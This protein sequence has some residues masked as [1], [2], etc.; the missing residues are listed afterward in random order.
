MRRGLWLATLIGLGLGAAPARA[1]SLSG[2][3]E[4]GNA[5]FYAGELDA[6]AE[7]Y[8][9]L[10]AAGVRDPDVYFNLATAYGRQ[11]KLGLA[12]LHY[13]R[14]LRL[15][16]GADD[17]VRGLA[18]AREALGHRRAERDGE[19]TVRTRPPLAETLVQPFSETQL[20]WASLVACL[21]LFGVLIVRRL[22]R[23]ETLRIG[24]GLAAPLLGLLL[25]LSGLGL[26][27]RADWLADGA[28]GV[29]LVED[30]ALREGPDPH[31][32]ERGQA[33]EGARARLFEREAGFVRVQLGDE[34]G[35]WLPADQVAAIQD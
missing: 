25:I 2:L 31:A 28:A 27:V 26:A 15:D 1:E 4:A 14:S 33:P 7:R 29:V 24:L 32:A 17:A 22:T 30:A 6:A 10:L 35:G 23:G 21:G 11:G 12:I 20:A 19:A 9:Q 16:P 3:F 18:L 5:A 13:E 34:L 8:E